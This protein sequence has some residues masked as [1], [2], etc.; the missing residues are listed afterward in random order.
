MFLKI[1]SEET[2]VIAGKTVCKMFFIKTYYHL[3]SENHLNKGCW[4]KTHFQ[5]NAETVSSLLLQQ[6]EQ[7]PGTIYYK[8]MGQYFITRRNVLYFPKAF[9][10][11]NQQL[12][13]EGLSLLEGHWQYNPVNSHR[14]PAFYAVSNSVNQSFIYTSRKT[15]Y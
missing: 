15:T 2:I 1:L 9:P 6:G 4:K 8:L 10:C 12:V 11:V 7:L 5:G 14:L 13:Y 3:I